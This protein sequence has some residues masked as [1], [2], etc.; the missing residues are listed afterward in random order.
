M[1]ALNIIT[2]TSGRPNF[3]NI[4][5]RSIR[6]Q[7]Y[8]NIKHIV[9]V[10]TNNDNTYVNRYEEEI[11]KIIRIP[12]GK[13]KHFDQYLNEALEYMPKGELFCMMDDD[14]FYTCPDALA[15]AV[16]ELGDGDICFYRVRA[17][18]GTVPSQEMMVSSNKELVM[19][20]LSM[21]GFI[22][23]T[24]FTYNSEGELIKF[25]EGYGGDFRFINTVV[26]TNS[27]G[28]SPYNNPRFKW[29]NQILASTNPACRQG[30]GK[31]NDIDLSAGIQGYKGASTCS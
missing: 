1:K 29:L 22:M 19:G 28:D 7:T 4:C 5:M 20:Q 12:E 21:L 16:I 8:N 9:L 11:D 27:T 10:D 23:S 25:S 31:Q 26:N 2:R 30:S 14:D 3:F 24:D 17:A 18:G 6:A 15:K 13:Y